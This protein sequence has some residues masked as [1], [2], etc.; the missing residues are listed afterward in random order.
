MKFTGCVDGFDA[1]DVILTMEP[2]DGGP[3]ERWTVER[4]TF[5]E[6]WLS[7]GAMC[8]LDIA[9]E[10]GRVRWTFDSSFITDAEWS[11]IEAE[12]KTL[13]ERFGFHR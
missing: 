11:K 12:A 6:K 4:R 8:E 9:V 10:G 7:L 1:T 3:R 13:A 5:P 2:D